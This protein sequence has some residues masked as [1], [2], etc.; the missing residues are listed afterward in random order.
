LKLAYDKLPDLIISDILM[1]DMD[2]F[3]LCRKWKA[4]D[5]LKHI[6][7]LFYTA[8]YT[9]TKDEVF[10]LSL[11][12][13]RFLVKPTAPDDLLLV[14][15][16]LITHPI[17]GKVEPAE[18]TEKSEVTYYK[19]Y[20]ETLIRK[21]EHKMEQINRANKRLASLYQASCELVTIKSRADIIHNALCAIIETA[22]YQQS[23]YFIYDQR[24]EKLF[25]LDAVGFSDQTATTFR[26]QLTF[27][28]GDASG[29]VGLVAES[30]Q[31]INISD[32]SQDDRWIVL[33]DRIKS[34]LFVPVNY[35]ENLFG[36]ISVFNK[37]VDAFNE[38][39]EQ[40]ILALANSIAI[41][42]K[43]R[44]SEGEIHKLNMELE[45]RVAERTKQLELSNR[46]L[47]A[48]AH[49]VSYDLRAPL[50]AIEGYSRILKDDCDEILTPERRQ[51]LDIILNNAN[52]MDHLISDLLV[53]SRANLN[54]LTLSTINM[55]ELVKSV[56]L[57]TALPEEQARIQFKVA[58]IPEASA[59]LNLIHQVFT[60]LISKSI[61][62]SLP[63][64]E[65]KILVNF[66]DEGD[67][68]VYTIE[69]NG[70]GFNPEDANAFIK[71]SEQQDFV[72]Y[73]ISSELDLAV[74]MRI[75]DRHHGKVW[76][77]GT[78]D[79]GTIFSFSLPK[80]QKIDEYDAE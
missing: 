66:R 63:A 36:V 4:D 26:E 46:E 19:A 55:M 21:L 15:N 25:L 31:N 45:R 3:S 7:F 58:S 33:D 65:P 27:K 78:L 1:P 60:N 9:D 49:S 39:D 56:Y 38:E 22:E 43:N 8:T 50:R 14:V 24:Y 75:M 72:N 40:N 59:D 34:A 71:V 37:E 44:D 67:M 6:P 29:L 53:I 77:E 42:F 80:E 74:V 30:R 41:T 32:T 17:V 11:G 73:Y 20:S 28:F 18:I 76:C 5:Q 62:Y 12:A 64:N 70:I 23:N 16:Q 51:L 48:F 79:K 57:E 69:S 2:G 13:E 61:Q 10:A 35:E 54:Q 68:V 52:K 47:E